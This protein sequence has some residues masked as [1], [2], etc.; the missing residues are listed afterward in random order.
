MLFRRP[1]AK[2]GAESWHRDESLN[3]KEGDTIYGGW[4]NLDTEPQYFSGCPKSHLEPDAM[5][6]NQGFARI[7]KKDYPRYNAMKKK[8]TIAPG[9]IFIFYERMVHEVLPSAKKEGPMSS[10][11]RMENHLS[12]HPLSGRSLTAIRR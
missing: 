10:V 8:I 2:P 6:R 7:D 12:E 11:S 9:D 5:R 4:I 1:P 3:A